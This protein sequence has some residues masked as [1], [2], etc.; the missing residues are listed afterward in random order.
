M[1]SRFLLQ[2]AYKITKTFLFVWA[3]FTFILLL[4]S[5]T[6]LPFWGIYRLAVAKSNYQFKP[7]YI[8]LMS[9]AAYPS[10]S[11]LLRTYYV[12]KALQK[13]PKS[14]LIIALPC[15]LK[16]TLNSVVK[17]QKALDLDTAKIKVL[18]EN[19]GTNTRA[20]AL[21]IKDNLKL[22]FQ[23]NILIVTAPEN[24]YRTILT[25]RKIGYKHLGGLPTFE[26]DL[27]IP[28]VFYTKDV[29]VKYWMPNVGA[30]TQLRYQFWNHLI[31]EIKL[32]REYTAI[33]YYKLNNWI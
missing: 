27:Q 3:V 4:I 8:V 12:K 29:A 31:Y 17:I 23:K 28:L 26:K 20:Q 10:K 16:D 33:L 7:D 14:K 11:T 21:F 6:S 1:Q 25:F 9:G 15:D 2:K 19:K 5:F 22:A 24:M 13:Y 30:N 18:V 32:L